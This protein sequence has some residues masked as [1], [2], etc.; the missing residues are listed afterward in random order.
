VT[1]HG[2]HGG[3]LGFL[4][5]QAAQRWRNEVSAALRDLDVTPPHFFVLITLLRQRKRQNTPLTQRDVAD[6]TGADANTTSQV[7]RALEDRALLV[8]VRHPTDSRA[9]ALSL[10]DEGLALARQCSLRVR[11]VNQQFFRNVEGASL[12]A[13]LTTLVITESG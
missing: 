2:T 8:R 3:G 4:L 1:D 9:I 12:A 5:V 13:Q 10:T 6:R 7:V 11:T